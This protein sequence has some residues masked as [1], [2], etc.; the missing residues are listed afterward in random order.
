MKSGDIVKH[1]HVLGKLVKDDKGNFLFLPVNFGRYSYSQLDVVTETNIDETTHNE[2][3]DYLRLE[4][5]WGV[6]TNVYCVGEYVIFEYISNSKDRK[7]V[8]FY[9]AFMDY[10]NIS[11]SYHTLDQCLVGTIAYKYDGGNS[12]AANYFYKMIGMNDGEM[13]GD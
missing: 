6:V 2:K 8:T 3:I 11:I 13:K 7:G 9:H 1:N 10:K 5:N 12:K 4:F